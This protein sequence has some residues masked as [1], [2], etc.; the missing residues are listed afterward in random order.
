MMDKAIQPQYIK[1]QGLMI[2]NVTPNFFTGSQASHQTKF[3]SDQK[4]LYK[5]L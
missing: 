2:S 5:H 4:P 3:M 1:W